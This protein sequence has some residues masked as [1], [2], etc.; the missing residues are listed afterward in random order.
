[1]VT[2]LDAPSATVDR[3][4]D[5]DR[6]QDIGSVDSW[7]LVAAARAG[8]TRAVAEIY[9]R[10]AR[11]IFAYVCHLLRD[12][13]LAEDV[14]SETFLRVIRNMDRIAFQ[15]RDLH[16]WLNRVARNLVLDHLRSASRRREIVVSRYEE[17]S[18]ADADPLLSVLAKASRDD[19]WEKVGELPVAQRRCLWLRFVE[20]RSVSETAKILE[21]PSGA[22]RALQHRAVRKLAAAF[23]VS[24]NETTIVGVE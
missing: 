4:T 6:H 8:D 11:P 16:A 17:L 24:Q 10:Y 7:K 15:G 9:R 3:G 14:T 21:R 5:D 13:T 1:M 2:V 12:E 23:D 22:V 20:G 18:N 19:L